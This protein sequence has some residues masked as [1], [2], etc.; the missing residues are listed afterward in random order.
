MRPEPC[1]M[2]EGLVLWLRG[3]AVAWTVVEHQLS[4]EGSGA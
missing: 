4:H 1:V 3:Q 2:R